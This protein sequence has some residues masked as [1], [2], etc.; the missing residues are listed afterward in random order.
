MRSRSKACSYPPQQ[1]EPTASVAPQ[2]ASK[3]DEATPKGSSSL[4][5]GGVVKESPGHEI[6][7]RREVW[8]S[9]S[10][11]ASLAVTV[12]SKGEP[13]PNETFSIDNGT[14]ITDSNSSNQDEQTKRNQSG[15]RHLR[16]SSQLSPYMDK[17]PISGIIMKTRYLSQSHWM[18][19]MT[20]LPYSLDWYDEQ[21]R[22]QGA[23]WQD[24]VT[25]RLLAR[26]IK[27]ARILSW[28]PG[29]YGKH[30]PTK[31][32]ADDLLDAYLRTFET[33]YRIIHVPTFKRAYDALWENLSMANSAY[34][35]QLQLCLCI[36]ACFYDEIFSLRPQALQWIGEAEH[37]L[38]S[39]GKLRLTVFGIQTMCLLHLAQQTAQHMQEHQICINSSALV[40]VAMTVGLHRDPTRLPNMPRFEIEIRRRLWATILELALDSGVD[41]GGS[42]MLPSDDFDCTLPLNLN[43]VELEIDK[44]G[45]FIQHE[46][47]EFTDTSIQIALGRTFASRLSIAKYVN[48]IKPDNPY[49]ETLRL[50][51]ELMTEYRSLI[52]SLHSLRPQPGKFQQQYCELMF[53]RYIFALHIAYMPRASSDPAQFYS[54]RTICADT[55]LRLT[56]FFLPQLPIPQEPPSFSTPSDSFRIEQNFCIET[57]RLFTC[58]SASFRSL[59]WQAVMV[60][61]AELAATVYQIHDT[62]PWM[63]VVPFNQTQNGNRIRS[64]ELLALLREAIDWTRRRVKAGQLNVK[65]LL[66]ITVTRAGIEAIMEGAPAEPAMDSKGKEALAEAIMILAEITGTSRTVIDNN[67][68]DLEDQRPGASNDFWSIGFSGTEWDTFFM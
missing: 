1:D 53:S 61:A 2:N 52:K 49:E 42:S 10:I 13:G 59:P 43:D 67:F 68:S 14:T 57:V 3:S 25:C 54:S 16:M 12:A 45:E 44:C 19:S 17:Y 35:V 41:A 28:T 63:G 55:A 27:A 66:W 38:Q 30:L 21:L 34:M 26:S 29:Q 60:I 24:L 15:V 31:V 47:S 8:K 32:I 4:A 6:F 20:L 40:R 46:A 18:F 7:A 64:I 36:G 50:S 37:W 62:S 65:D 5:S 9:S 56:S 51:S 58:G 39:S 23:I 33:I 48:G 22:R 11:G